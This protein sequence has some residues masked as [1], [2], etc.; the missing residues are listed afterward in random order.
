MCIRDRITAPKNT[1]LKKAEAI[2]EQHKIEKLP[3]IDSKGILVGLIT[4]K[5]ILKVRNHPNSSKDKF[6]RLL[7]G[8]AVGVTPD[9]HQRIEALAHV[10]V[11][12]VIIDTCLLYTSRCV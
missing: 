12:V 8:A 10:G 5:D 1:D 6:G 9:M 4:Y 3:V 2:L 11:D 7:C